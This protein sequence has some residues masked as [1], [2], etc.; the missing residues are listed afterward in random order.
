MPRKPTRRAPEP[1][2]G[3]SRNLE[4][5]PLDVREFDDRAIKWI[6]ECPENLRGAMLL[7]DEK[8]ADRLDFTHMEQMRTTLLPK[9]LRSRSAD[10][11]V[12]VPY[13]SPES[14]KSPAVYVFV[15]MEHQ[16]EPDD[17]VVFWL[18]YGMVLIWEREIRQ[19]QKLGA[20]TGSHKLSPIIPLLL[21]TGDRR[22]S[23]PLSLDVIVALPELCG[24]FVPRFSFLALNMPD[25]SGESLAK[26][27]IGAVLE[28]LSKG[29]VS[30]AELLGAIV[31]AAE[32]LDE[33]EEKD[34]D[35]VE[36]AMTILY[37]LLYHRRP[38]EEGDR[39]KG[40]LEQQLSHKKEMSGIMRT[41]ADALMEKGK[42]IGI[43]EG[44]KLGIERGKKIGVEEGAL[45]A[46]RR[47]A[48]DLLKQK[49]GELPERAER[50]LLAMDLAGLQALTLAVLSANSLDDLG[51]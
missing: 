24:P 5:A 31:A 35:A 20:V 25:A 11:L 50:R 14:A 29:N 18:L 39:L 6:M 1:V 7:L 17:L 21:Y 30:G 27:P 23:I 8:L 2:P 32:R 36:R 42:K 13:L 19:W 49:F 16:S 48:G 10:L 9:D 47:M 38:E 26:H 51:L 37:L 41:M 4:T 22:W 43:E 44:E 45:S 12:R 15:L 3:L 46:T 33:L 28:A 34:R 40:E